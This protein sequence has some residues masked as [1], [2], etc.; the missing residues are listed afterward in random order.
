[1]AWR[2]Q[3]QAI[4]TSHVFVNRDASLIGALTYAELFQRAGVLARRLQAAGVVPGDRVLVMTDPGEPSLLGMYACFCAGAVAVPVPP[5]MDR[6]QRVAAD[7]KPRAALVGRLQMGVAQLMAA[8]GAALPSLVD[9]DG[10][11]E[12]PALKRREL[13]RA[14]G[15]AVLQYTSGSTGDPKGVMVTHE[16]LWHLLELTEQV[17]GYGSAT[18]LVNW[19]P[20]FHDLGLIG[21]VLQPVFSGFPAA[22]LSPLAFLSQPRCWLQTISDFRA[23]TSA[24]PNFAYELCVKRV[25]PEQRVGL[26]LSSLVTAICAG[27]PIM[28]ATLESFCDAFGEFGFDRSALQ[29]AYGLAE[30]TLETAIAARGRG[31]AR[32]AVDAEALRRGEFRPQNSN[33][34]TLTLVA[35]GSPVQRTLIVD[36][37]TRLPCAPG[38]VG[39]IWIDSPAVAAGYYGRPEATQQTFRACVAGTESPEFLRTGDMGVLY[40]GDLF[41]TGRSKDLIIIRGENHW[42]QDI[43]ATAGAAHASVRPGC[44]AA[45]SVTAGGSEQLVVVAEVSASAGA[46]SGEVL[47]AIAGAVKRGHRLRATVVLTAPRSVPKT[48]SGKLQRRACREAFLSGV[49]EVV[50]RQNHHQDPGANHA[51]ESRIE[52]QAGPGS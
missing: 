32:C 50:A 18:R 36:P 6:V 28:H 44:V 19:L 13:P 26:D 3:T 30:A 21:G 17:E 12:G 29:P 2:A 4:R 31:F 10:P 40:E 43:E 47:E 5:A 25:L 33:G 49:L 51:H 46:R 1:L 27:E 35:S 24:A 39:E 52:Y 48:T 8:S 14:E 45:F 34:E 7:C 9:V 16:N 41:V 37:A 15:L 42:P 38:A 22:L 20:T 11:Y 23:T